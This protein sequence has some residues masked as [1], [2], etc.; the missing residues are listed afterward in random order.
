[1]RDALEFTQ[2][3]QRQDNFPIRKKSPDEKNNDIG[4]M[5]HELSQS[6]G[7]IDWWNDYHFGYNH[8][9]TSPW[10]IIALAD[11]FHATGDTVFVK[12]SWESVKQAYN[13]CK[14]KDSNNDG[15]MDLKGAG[16]GV[17]EFGKLV[18]IHNDMYTQAIW[19]Q[20]LKEMIEIAA[21]LV[22]NET[23][24]EAKAL[25]AK[26]SENLEKIYWME[27]EGY[28]SYGAGEDGTQVKVKSPYSTI[29]QM[30]SLLDKD[31]SVSSMKKMNE[32]D[33][34][35]DWGVRSLSN[36]SELYEPLNYNYGAVWP[37]TCKF[38]SAAEYNFNF[39]ILGLANILIVY[40]HMFE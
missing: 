4:K 39:N 31:R 3:W 18:K 14:T 6:E 2:K 38:F 12:R 30:F 32:P 37:F 7:L 35:T 33:L 29:A 11:Y 10:Y 17:L 23:Q 5:A 27:D 22:D 13:W 20:A 24:K 8:A 34:V 40:H 9:D 19:T 25:Y 15:L 28:Y 1:V 21:I 16:L 36:T 26:A